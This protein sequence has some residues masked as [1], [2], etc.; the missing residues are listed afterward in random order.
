MKRTVLCALFALAAQW[1]SAQSTIIYTRGPDPDSSTLLPL[2]PP[3]SLDMNDDGSADLAFSMQPSICTMDIPVSMC[4]QSSFVS[5]PETSA[6]LI[7]DH[8]AANIA[9][10]EWIGDSAPSNTTWSLA[11]DVKLA[12]YWFSP[13]DGTS[14]VRGPI[15]EQGDGYVGVRFVADDGVHYGW[16]YLKQSSII[17]WA[18][19][20]RPSQPIRAGYKPVV[21][22]VARVSTDRSGFLRL[23]A[24]TEE[25]KTYQIQVKES[26]SDFAWSNL[27]F[28]LPA[29]STNTAVDIPMNE[30]H[31][32][33]RVVEAD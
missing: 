20:S 32:F 26:L 14:G 23:V 2:M 9:H 12:I 33:F 21:T 13:K 28:A 27:N 3:V 8:F 17:E 10:G 6:I 29:S 7:A 5:V 22:P 1:A 11:R 31:A 24:E 19:E 18:Y 15:A 30:R 25:G 4:S 16:V